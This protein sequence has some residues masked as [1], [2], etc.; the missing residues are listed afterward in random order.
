MM[1]EILN[2]KTRRLELLVLEAEKLPQLGEMRRLSVELG[3]RAAQAELA[4]NRAAMN[5]W[6]NEQ[7]ALQP[8]IVELCDALHLVRDE[9]EAGET[10]KRE[11]EMETKELLRIMTARLLPH[12][13]LCIVG[14]DAVEAE[15]AH[16]RARYAAIVG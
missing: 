14:P 8:A 1:A 4:D 5:Q 16:L 15:M 12:L 2:I 11:L 13:A 10:K 6:R 3:N 7:M 9:I